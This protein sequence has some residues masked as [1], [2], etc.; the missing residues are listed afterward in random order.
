MI[1]M[2]KRAPVPS[3]L[4]I[5]GALALGCGG[6]D[7]GDDSGGDGGGDECPTMWSGKVVDAT[8]P[9]TAVGGIKVEVIDDV[10]G[11]PLS[12]PVVVTAGAD[13]SVSV[14]VPAGTGCPKFG[15]KAHANDSYT[16]TYSY[17]VRP[18]SSGQPDA[19]VRM[20]GNN[21]SAL[22]PMAA[23]YDVKDNAAPAAGAVYWKLP[24]DPVYDVVGCAQIEDM[25]GDIVAQDLRYFKDAIPSSTTD[26]P[27]AKGTR[28]GDGR[29][30]VGNMT[31]GKHTLVGKVN[32]TEIGRTD[33]VIFPRTEAATMVSGHPAN[34]FLAG[35]YIDAKDGET[36]PTPAD[37]QK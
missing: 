27:L 31:P 4:L 12:P 37:C 7:G 11:L 14:P 26:W 20:G 1:R 28:K 36:N 32:G 13:G 23:Q 15:I 29:F 2:M 33:I 16:D 8:T 5:A 34:L 35:I 3:L 21:T 6:D 10:T 25:G 9:S 30:F 19:L 18:N 17:H 24:N 22:V